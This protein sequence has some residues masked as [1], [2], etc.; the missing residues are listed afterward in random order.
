MQVCTGCLTVFCCA[1]L[2]P[3]IIL[4]NPPWCPHVAKVYRFAD[5]TAGLDTGRFEV[6]CLV[7]IAWLCMQQLLKHAHVH[8]QL[9]ST[10]AC[11]CLFSCAVCPAALSV[12]VLALA[13]PP[14]R[15]PSGPHLA[16]DASSG[17]SC[18]RPLPPWPVRAYCLRPWKLQ[19]G[20]SRGE[21]PGMPRVSHGVCQGGWRVQVPLQAFCLSAS[22]FTNI[23]GC[24]SHFKVAAITI[25]R[26]G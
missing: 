2:P 24:V 20:S 5:N 17:A 14:S 16:C 6:V 10:I 23:K 12:R 7:H 21:Q 8:G 19:P 1:A 26:P 22:G 15:C 3:Y 25:H 9:G 4:R 13:S 18:L 11:S